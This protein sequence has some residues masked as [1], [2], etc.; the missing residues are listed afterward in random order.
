LFVDGLR[1]ISAIAVTIFHIYIDEIPSPFLDILSYGVYVFFVLSGFVIAHSMLRKNLSCS[2]FGWFVIRRSMRLDPPYWAAILLA[3]SI[4]AIPILLNRRSAQPFPSQDAIA[5]QFF[6]L[7]TF[8]GYQQISPAFWTLAY[9]IQFYIV[10]AF[11]LLLFALIFKISQHDPRLIFFFLLLFFISIACRQGAFP[12][13]SGLFLNYWFLFLLGVF[14]RW[15]LEIKIALAALLI[16][17]L[18][19]IL[20]NP[21]SHAENIVGPLTA[22][23]LFGAGKSGNLGTWLNQSW[24]QYLG[25]ISYSLY[26]VHDSVGPFVRGAFLFLI[27]KTKA[28]QDFPGIASSLACA[29]GLIVSLFAAHWFWLKIELPSHSFSRRLG[30]SE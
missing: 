18:T 10:F 4:R 13:V 6:Y 12:S 30:P 8:L 16:A 26:L 22:M 25:T 11:L 28:F 27:M 20:I 7:Q 1:G 5:S 21:S 24:I 17:C 15:A 23:S 14:S 3:L 29:L 2:L 9:E 19:C